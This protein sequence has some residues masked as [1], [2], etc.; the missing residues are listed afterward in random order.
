M[1]PMH[2]TAL[3]GTLGL[4]L[5]TSI[6]WAQDPPR[7]T[8][9]IARPE[10]VRPLRPEMTQRFVALHGSL[11]P[12]AKAW[13]EQQARIE[14]QRPTPDLAELRT[15]IR[16]RFSASLAGGKP[17]STGASPIDIPGNDVE[18]MVFVVLMQAT[19]DADLDLQQ[20][21]DQV[22]AQTAAKQRLRDLI[23]RV[24]HD[25]ASANTG[26][27]M[28][29][30]PCRTGVCQSLPGELRQLSAAT[31]QSKR[32]MRMAVP[33]NLTYGQLPQVASQLN[34]ELDSM[35]DLSTEQ[36]LQMQMIMDRRSKLEE[37]ISNIMK[38]L[39]DTSNSIVGNMK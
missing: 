9:M 35:N 32:P 3:R 23:N 27:N 18:E 28:A 20:I 30:Q 1:K 29:K 16:A 24:N 17:S 25:V 19:N 12:S 5:G 21:M 10:Q 14:A 39:Q 36:Q 13:V 33:E 2:R 7:R 4:L 26:A 6:L 8:E 31:A 38:K 15:Q 22:K 34:Q 11:Q 37:A